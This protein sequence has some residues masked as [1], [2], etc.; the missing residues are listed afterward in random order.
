MYFCSIL[1][2]GIEEDALVFCLPPLG[3]SEQVR[4]EPFTGSNAGTLGLL[5][6]SLSTVS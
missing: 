2:P 1:G 6:H 4:R 3:A 5:S